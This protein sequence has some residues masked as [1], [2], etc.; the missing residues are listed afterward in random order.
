VSC[1]HGSIDI[2]FFE[3]SCNTFY[4]QLILK[5]G[6]DKW[7]E[8]AHKFGFGERTGVDIGEELPGLVPSRLYYDKVWGKNRWGG[9]FLVSLGIGQG[10]LST[11]IIQLAQ[12][13]C[14]LANYVKL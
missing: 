7:N 6:I 9:G 4:Y 14:L 12:Y 10:E 8:Y 11:T 5:I 13:T 1:P 3:K 2:T